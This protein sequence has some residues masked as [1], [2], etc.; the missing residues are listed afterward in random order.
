MPFPKKYCQ[1]AR[2]V[3]FLRRRHFGCKK[4]DGQEIVSETNL[5][6]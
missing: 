5:S 6:S 3:D 1:T 4:L 2:R